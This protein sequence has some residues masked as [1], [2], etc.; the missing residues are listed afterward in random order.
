MTSVAY[1]AKKPFTT[2][3]QVAREGAPAGRR[4]RGRR[5]LASALSAIDDGR[6]LA[7]YSVRFAFALH[8]R[9]LLHWLSWLVTLSVAIAMTAVLAPGQVYG[10]EQELT[11]RAQEVP[12]PEVL[13]ALASIATDGNAW[14]AYLIIGVVV[15]ALWQ[16][17]HPSA[18]I[19]V[20][21]GFP[22]FILSMGPKNLVDR[23]RPSPVFDGIEGVGGAYSFPSGHAA[24]TLTFYGFLLY[25]LLIHLRGRWQ[26]AA[27]VF[28]WLLFALAVAVTRVEH[29]RHWPLDILVAWAVG[30]GVLSGLVWLHRALRQATEY[31]HS[32]GPHTGRLTHH[33]DGSPPGNRFRVTGVC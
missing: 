10:W 12:E 26:R 24:F 4:G 31:K 29:G 27:V 30:L 8:R 28:L 11:H 25:L 17:K 15:L 7:R 21:L 32:L 16:L 14:P 5:T 6:V 3:Q 13:F 22:L 23:P 1:R 33:H 9:N 2:E 20:A 18:A 19:T